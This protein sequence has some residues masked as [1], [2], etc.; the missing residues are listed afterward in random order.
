MAEPLEDPVPLENPVTGDELAKRPQRASQTP[1][2]QPGPRPVGR[3]DSLAQTLPSSVLGTYREKPCARRDA[4]KALSLSVPTRRNQ[5]VL[6]CWNSEELGFLALTLFSLY[7]EVL[8]SVS[9]EKCVWDLEVSFLILRPQG[10]R[11]NS[12]EDSATSFPPVSIWME[13]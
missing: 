4:A 11:L 3:G 12:E 6:C 10:M 2:G 9:L 13:G 1:R 8:S 5:L 7:C